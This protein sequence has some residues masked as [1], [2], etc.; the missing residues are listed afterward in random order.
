M[1]IDHS[2]AIQK[3]GQDFFV[4][5]SMNEMSDVLLNFGN[6]MILFLILIWIF[7]ESL[8]LLFNKKRRAIHDFIANTIVIVTKPVRFKGYK[9]WALFIIVFS[10]VNFCY[11][12]IYIGKSEVEK[13]AAKEITKCDEMDSKFFNIKDKLGRSTLHHSVLNRN[14][15]LFNCLLERSINVNIQDLKGN[16][17]LHYAVY[18]SYPEMV[19]GLLDNGGNPQIVNLE[20]ERPI[21]QAFETDTHI[22]SLKQHNIKNQK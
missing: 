21:D 18:W 2:I 5:L 20:G 13:I 16:T 3:F 1:L 7:S 9:I 8:V 12:Q 14:I 6:P 15:I 10:I 19:K 4:N 11:F 22:L 17:P